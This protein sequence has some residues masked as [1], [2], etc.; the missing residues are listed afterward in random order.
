[1]EGWKIGRLEDWR[2]G[3]LPHKSMQIFLEQIFRLGL[4]QYKIE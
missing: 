1:L 4:Y 3:G 2:E